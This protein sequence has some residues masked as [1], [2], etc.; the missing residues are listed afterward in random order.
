MVMKNTQISN[1]TEVCPVGAEF[2]HAGRQT[3][4]MKSLF[5]ICKHT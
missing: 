3:D 2:L 4:M 1:F 5:A